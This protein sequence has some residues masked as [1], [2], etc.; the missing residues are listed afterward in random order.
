[1]HIAL[2][3]CK[4]KMRYVENNSCYTS[5][6][7]WVACDGAPHT[8]APPNQGGLPA[9]GYVDIFICVAC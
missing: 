8:K 3:A 7:R 1:M 9:Y 4:R 6:R 5:V 2:R